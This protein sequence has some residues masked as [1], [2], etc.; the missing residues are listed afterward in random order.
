MQ[1]HSDHRATIGEPGREIHS[2]DAEFTVQDANP[3]TAAGVYVGS[4]SPG[5]VGRIHDSRTVEKDADGQCEKPCPI[6]RL[7]AGKAAVNHAL[8]GGRAREQAVHGPWMRA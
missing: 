2:H 6:H 5:T 1:S 3:D 8:P 4:I 7:V